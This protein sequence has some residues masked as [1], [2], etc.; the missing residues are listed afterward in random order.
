MEIAYNTVRNS[1]TENHTRVMIWIGSGGSF[2]SGS[3]SN[4]KFHHNTVSTPGLIWQVLSAFDGSAWIDHNT[5]EQR[6]VQF[7][8]YQYSDQMRFENWRSRTG[9]DANS[10][11]I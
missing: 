6:G 8:I 10:S 2:G 5:Y 4:F 7:G 1:L 9:K 3:T 11:S